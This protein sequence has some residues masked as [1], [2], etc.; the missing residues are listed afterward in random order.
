[1]PAAEIHVGDTGVSFQFTVKDQDSVAVDVSGATTKQL[2]FKKPGGTT[3]TQTASF[4]TD[5][6][7]GKIEYISDDGDLDE[8]GD[9]E[10]QVYVVLA[11]GK[12]HTQR[13]HFKVFANIS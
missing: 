3:V 9:W 11:S 1:M 2:K 4:V 12:K 7:D 13:Q 8:A 5:G 10:I 6:T